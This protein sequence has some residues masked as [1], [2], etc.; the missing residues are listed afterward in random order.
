[1][2]ETL[3]RDQAASRLAEL[4]AMFLEILSEEVQKS[5]YYDEGVW[6]CE[7]VYEIETHLS[8][9]EWLDELCVKQ[10]DWAADWHDVYLQLTGENV[11]P[12]RE[13][14]RLVETL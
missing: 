13:L 2:T 5:G 11:E 4:K 7:M 8:I 12:W 9:E 3:T 10:P 1:M 6:N 14:K